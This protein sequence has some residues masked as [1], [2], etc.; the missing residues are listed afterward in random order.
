LWSVISIEAI[1]CSYYHKLVTISA[2]NQSDTSGVRIFFCFT[3]EFAVIEV[4]L[5]I[6]RCKIGLKL[7]LRKRLL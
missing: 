6:I 1:T 4:I 3:I 5:T 2:R 7:K